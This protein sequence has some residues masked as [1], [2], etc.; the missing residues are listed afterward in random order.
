MLFEGEKNTEKKRIK[1]QC[2]LYL[3]G[4]L[5]NMIHDSFFI[6]K[7]V[8]ISAV[9]IQ[10]KWSRYLKWTLMNILYPRSISIILKILIPMFGL[11]AIIE[12][13]QQSI[14]SLSEEIRKLKFRWQTS[15]STYD[16]R[17]LLSKWWWQSSYVTWL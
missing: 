15:Y 13:A 9:E 5:V 3:S 17:H 2:S 12:I 10:Y 16:Y 14:F 6:S 11:I 4:D 8:D 7:W 1:S